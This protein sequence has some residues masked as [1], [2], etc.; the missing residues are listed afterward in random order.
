MLCANNVRFYACVTRFNN[1]T[2]R[3]NERFRE[4]VDFDGCIYGSPSEMPE[5]IPHK[6]RIFVFEMN[7]EE[8]KIMGIGYLYKKL[9]YSRRYKIYNINDYNRFCYIGKYRVDRYEIS[10]PQ[11]TLLKMIETNIFKGQTHQKRG[12]GFNCISDK[13]MRHIN[14][15]LLPWLISIFQEKYGF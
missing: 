14:K 7:N 10:K 6:S 9:N 12:H 8:N 1:T 3:E 4:N 2:F 13:N 15:K 11:Q 5:H